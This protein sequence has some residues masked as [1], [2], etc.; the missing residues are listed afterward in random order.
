MINLAEEFLFDDIFKL[1]NLCG[2][3][4]EAANNFVDK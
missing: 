2:L 3:L 4:S 1:E